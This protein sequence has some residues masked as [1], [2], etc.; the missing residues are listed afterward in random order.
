MNWLIPGLTAVLFACSGTR[1]L[2]VEKVERAGLPPYEEGNR[3]YRLEGEGWERLR[4]GDR[5]A[6]RRPGQ[7]LGLGLLVVHEIHQGYVLATQLSRG[8]TFPMNGDLAEL[9]EVKPLPLLPSKPLPVLDSQKLQTLQPL[10]VVKA[11]A[12]AVKREPIYF[13][14]KDASLSPAG[15][16]K[17]QDWVRS[18]G[19]NGNWALVYPQGQ[20]ND[21]SLAL[22]RVAAIQE[23][24]NGLGVS[25]IEVR[26]AS[27]IQEGRFD[28]IFIEREHR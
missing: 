28:T 18:W 14:K 11:T 4:V 19:K 13:L 5:I 2:H 7:R 12:L 8:E 23:F 25:G 6:L 21:A 17:L 22:A 15:K 27:I 9:V 20:G 16:E 26:S 10:T 24:M 3:L 1:Q